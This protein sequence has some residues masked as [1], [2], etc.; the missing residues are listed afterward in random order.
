METLVNANPL[1]N[2]LY[3]AAGGNGKPILTRAS[4]A[5][6]NGFQT[7]GL[8][9][10]DTPKPG[11]GA[12]K[13]VLGAYRM[14]D[15]DGIAPGSAIYAN[16]IFSPFKDPLRKYQAVLF[17]ATGFNVYQPSSGDKPTQALL[18][19]MS[20]I[21][22]KAK[23][24]EP[25]AD[26]F[27][28]LK[29]AKDVD[30]AGRSSGIG[31]LVK[32]REIIRHVVDM[33]RE[34]NN[35]DYLRRMLD[36]GL[37]AEDAQKEIDNVKKANALQEAK[38]IED[39]PYQSKLLIARVAQKRGL[40]SMINEPL[41]S[42]GAINNPQPN[43][44]MSAMLGKPGQGFGESPLD[45]NRL[46]MTPDFYK[47][48]LRRTTMTEESA[49]EQSAM[50]N[51]LAQ[52]E[53]N[54]E[55]IQQ[56]TEEYSK[57]NVPLTGGSTQTG[58]S[59]STLSAMQKQDNIERRKESML[60]NLDNL[61][62][63][64]QKTV[65]ALPAIV[66]A[67]DVLLPL[68]GSSKVGSS[69]S[70]SAEIIETL[71]VAHL[72]LSINISLV[73]RKVSANAIKSLI[74][75]KRNL[76]GNEQNPK[77]SVVQAL[78]EIAR[79]LNAD[80]PNM[81][82]PFSTRNMK[83]SSVPFI[84]KQIDKFISLSDDEINKM[85]GAANR[86][87]VDEMAKLEEVDMAQFFNSRSEDSMNNTIDMAQSSNYHSRDK[88]KTYK[89][90]SVSASRRDGLTDVTGNTAVP[91]PTGDTGGVILVNEPNLQSRIPGPTRQFN[92]PRL[93]TASQALINSFNQSRQR[94]RVPIPR[95]S[96]SVFNFQDLNQQDNVELNNTMGGG[97]TK[98]ST[99]SGKGRMTIN[100]R[101]K[102]TKFTAEEGSRGYVG[103]KKRSESLAPAPAPALT[104][105]PNKSA[106]AK[107]WK[108]WAESNGIQYTSVK[109][110]AEKYKK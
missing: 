92:L 20:A 75:S 81:R 104:A 98:F 71:D 87:F 48:M 42:S 8:P 68:Y 69:V 61:R 29:L 33:R 46:F 99:P 16:D 56:M 100:G 107:A 94:N 88:A 9:G 12:N 24:N 97:K 31:D 62:L 14:G 93:G 89:N 85:T 28:Q 84:V 83:L 30:L 37:S 58:I 63:R 52:G 15:Q 90:R 79:V 60:A 78:R 21:A 4:N 47:G 95:S 10:A 25:F 18:E 50:A 43:G 11:G 55:S 49:Q 40:T 39:R 5:K 53:Q 82:I 38:K 72:F 22:E 70:T 65:F 13:T 108:D 45:L 67:E 105:T 73:T 74:Q 41:T 51:L 109:D 80:N 44:V 91:A 101:G 102:V 96:E 59:A 103:N 32:S 2:K 106:P 7:F 19:R 34:Q 76:I 36:A 35:A 77:P 3:Y 6:V 86:R 26:Y 66:F 57:N 23:D 110:L 54:N 27:A 64:S 1:N 17:P